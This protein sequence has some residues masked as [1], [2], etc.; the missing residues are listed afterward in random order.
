MGQRTSL[1]SPL[2]SPFLPG[3]GRP[4]QG[5]APPGRPGPGVGLVTCETH[6]PCFGET[7]GSCFGDTW[8]MFCSRLAPPAAR[9]AFRAVCRERQRG[10][11]ADADKAYSRFGVRLSGYCTG[12]AALPVEWRRPGSCLAEALGL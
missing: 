10:S 1:C 4:H 6:G 2:R 12:R 3:E 7:H 9:A 11:D 8:V 5:D